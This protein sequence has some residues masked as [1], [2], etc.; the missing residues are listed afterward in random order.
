MD[1]TLKTV[2]TGMPNSVFPA[3]PYDASWARTED[4]RS[5]RQ[6]YLFGAFDRGDGEP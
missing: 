1:V 5:E 4:V 2:S 3:Q 6:G